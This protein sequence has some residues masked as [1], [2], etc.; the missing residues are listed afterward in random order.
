MP[1]RSQKSKSIP[2]RYQVKD[3]DNGRVITCTESPNVRVLIKRGQSTS[4]SAAHKAETRTIFLDGAAQSPPFLDNDKQIYNLD[5]H[6]GVVRAFTL[7]T[8]EQALL[9]V[10]RG[11]DLRERNWT[12]IANDPD[13]D[14]VLAIWVLVNH[15]RLSEEDSSGMQEIVPL[16]RLE[17]V[18]DAHGLEMNRFTGLPASALKEAEKKLEKLRAKELEIKKTGEWENIDYA[19]YCAETL[20]KIDGLVYRPLEFHDYHDVDELAR[21][22]TNTGRDVVFCDSDLGVYELEQ[23]LTKLY[24]TQPGVIVLQKSP[25]VFTLRQVDLFLP[26][27]L[28]PVYARLNFVD[29]AVRD[30]GNTWGGSGEIG[31]SPRSTGTK[32]SLKEIADAFRVTYRRPGVWDHIR[33]FLYAVFITAAVFIPA[34]FIA[35]NL[36]TL[37]DWSGIGST[38]AGRDALQSL[39][40]TYPLVL[41]LIV[42]AV[43][44]LAGKRNRVYGFDIPAGH[45]WLYLLPLALMAAVSG[46]VWI[47]EL[48]DPAHG[49]VSIGFLTLSQI[50]MLAVFLLPI[51]AEL[52][53]RGFLHGFLAERYPCQHVAGQW[54]V[55]YPT[56]ITASFYGLITLILP[57]QTP[58]L[59]D[60]ALN[61]WDWFT[62]VNQIA[63]FFS[64]VLF[65]IV[66]GSVRERSGSILPAIGT[67][68][69][70]A[71]LV[72]LFI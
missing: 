21:V 24:G 51:S 34:F 49:N 28:E 44:F 58:P 55:S 7:A 42:P 23:Y 70:I 72:A 48:S 3:S 41:I 20:R 8:C 39:Q 66:A 60:L 27:N 36:F 45:D 29:P 19:D 1:D 15:L 16:I 38:Y 10:M 11:L 17:G 62:R 52:L 31:G 35:H 32:L 63:G 67:H 47:P 56:F 71:P 5:H 22:E 12:I 59:H 13:L 4:D 37:F 9:L 53:F 26:E 25:G 68:L 33:N 54:F 57:L 6:H 61:H 30:A 18:I 2:D 50:Q 46:G 40:N 69:L 14:T 64:A 65:G 43:Y